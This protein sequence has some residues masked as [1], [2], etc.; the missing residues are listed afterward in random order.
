MVAVPLAVDV[1]L[2]EPHE[3]TG[4][5]L[6]LTPWLVESLATV[7]VTGAELEVGRVVGGA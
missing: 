4:A 5:Q 2:K 1:G 7:A 3:P 6:Q